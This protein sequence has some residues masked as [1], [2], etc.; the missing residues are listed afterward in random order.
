MPYPLAVG[1][2]KG[3]GKPSPY[4][5]RRYRRIG[6]RIYQLITLAG[7]VRIAGREVTDER[8]GKIVIER[9]RGH[10]PGGE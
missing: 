6:D 3:D 8:T 10:G 2:A 4:I 7:E 5:D 1:P 9:E